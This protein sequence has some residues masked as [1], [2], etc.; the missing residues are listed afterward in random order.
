MVVLVTCKNED[1]SITNED[2]KILRIICQCRISRHTRVASSAVHDQIWL[3][4]EHI[5]DTMVVFVTCNNE[6]YPIQTCR[7]WS[8]NK[9]IHI[10]TL[11]ELSVAIETSFDPVWFKTKC[12]QSLCLMM[13][14]I[15]FGC[16]WPAGLRY[17]FMFESVNARTGGPRLMYHPIRTPC[18]SSTQV[19]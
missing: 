12:S 19:S 6:E 18:E 16:S 3:K 2:N 10:I 14:Q 7:R 4:F 15:K 5:R 8:V 1:D 13:L 9:I 17:S 11:C